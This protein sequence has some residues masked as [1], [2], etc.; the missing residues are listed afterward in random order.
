MNGLDAGG[1]PAS[2]TT[3]WVLEWAAP[4]G[5]PIPPSSLHRSEEGARAR[6]AAEG[7]RLGVDA[8]AA[9]AA[10]ETRPGGMILGWL[11]KT[12]WMLRTLS[13]ED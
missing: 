5:T 12:A 2:R 6:I 1:E 3:I 4:T 10:E 7:A 8:D 9:Q 13:L 11:G